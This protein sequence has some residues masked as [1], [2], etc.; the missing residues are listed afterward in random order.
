ML[1]TWMTGRAASRAVPSPRLWRARPHRQ[2]RPHRAVQ[3]GTSSV[4]PLG[5]A[6]GA[7]WREELGGRSGGRSV[8]G[9]AVGGRVAEQHHD[10]PCLASR[11][12]PGRVFVRRRRRHRGAVG[13]TSFT[14][15]CRYTV[16][17][18]FY[19]GLL[20]D[21]HDIFHF[22]AVV[23][24]LFLD[25]VG[26]V[27]D[28]MPIPSR[29]CFLDV[30]MWSLRARGSGLPGRGGGGRRRW[31]AAADSGGQGSVCGGR[32]CGRPGYGDLLSVGPARRSPGSRGA[33]AGPSTP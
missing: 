2:S 23:L 8:R 7:A 3:Y 17:A 19:P 15:G 21:S 6:L 31:G 30:E 1:L 16:G 4:A 28:T 18:H 11:K 24:R 33:G 20:G 29:R 13:R 25:H 14:R 32:R 5:R 22:G 12:S 26:P 27:A 10:I 9:P